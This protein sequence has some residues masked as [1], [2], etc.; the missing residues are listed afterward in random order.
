MSQTIIMVLVN[1]AAV[2]LPRFGLE[3]GSES[4]TTTITTLAAIFSAIYIWYRRVQGG[5]VSVG[6]FRK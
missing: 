4:L 5:D 1:L 6:G 2:V 3:I